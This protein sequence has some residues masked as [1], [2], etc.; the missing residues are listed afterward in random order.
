MSTE[1]QE[2][3]SATNKTVAMTSFHGGSERGRCVQLTQGLHNAVQLTEEQAL[4]ALAVL[5]NW[6]ARN[7]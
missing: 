7:N 2:L 6:L 4:Q 5:S 1:L 3:T